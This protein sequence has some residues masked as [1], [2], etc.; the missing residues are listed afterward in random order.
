MFKHM[1]SWYQVANQKSLLIINHTPTVQDSEINTVSRLTFVTLIFKWIK[2]YPRWTQILRI[3]SSS[4]SFLA[5]PYHVCPVGS[6]AGLA[7]SDVSTSWTQLPLHK[8]NASFTFCQ[9]CCI[10]MG[11]SSVFF[12]FLLCCDAVSKFYLEICLFIFDNK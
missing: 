7:T 4:R 11:S 1:S 9:W 5:S 2:I 10:V 12:P 8:T 6:T 3:H